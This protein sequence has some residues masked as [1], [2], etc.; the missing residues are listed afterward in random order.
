MLILFD[1]NINIQLL[2][3]TYKPLNQK[4]INYQPFKEYHKPQGIYQM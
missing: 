4:V 1:S 2:G 3:L